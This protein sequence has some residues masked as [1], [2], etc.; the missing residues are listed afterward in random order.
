MAMQEEALLRM[1]MSQDFTK[2]FKRAYQIFSDPD[3]LIGNLFLIIGKSMTPTTF[4]FFVD[5]LYFKM[6]ESN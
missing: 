2:I 1:Q 5:A 6:E 4:W 3:L